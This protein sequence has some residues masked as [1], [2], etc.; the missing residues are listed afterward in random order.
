[1]EKFI[2]GL[3]NCAECMCKETGIACNGIKC[4]QNSLKKKSSLGRVRRDVNEYMNITASL[5]NEYEQMYEYDSDLLTIN[6]DMARAL[7]KNVYQRVMNTSLTSASTCW[8][9]TVFS[10]LRYQHISRS[11]TKIDYRIQSVSAKRFIDSE[12]MTNKNVIYTSEVMVTNNS[13]LQQQV[14][15][16]SYSLTVTKTDEMTISKTSGIVSDSPI[17]IPFVGSSSWQMEFSGAESVTKVRT[18]QF[19]IEAPMQK[20]LLDP[21]TKMSL[22]FSFYQF[23]TKNNYQVDLDVSE[24]AMFTMPDFERDLFHGDL[25]CCKPCFLFKTND[26]ITTSLT[27]VLKNNPNL[28]NAIGYANQ[29]QIHLQSSKN[30]FT[31]TNFPMYEKIMNFGCDILYGAPEH[32]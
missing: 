16:L 17:D 20:V 2:N 5:A 7:A 13:T 8:V 14:S 11:L 27:Q 29:G 24:S 23:E 32:I 6:V 21:A 1:M 9:S 18:Q 12:E 26:T 10:Y 19:T 3:E 15:T 25:D 28:L 31:L 4:Q 30:G 22:K